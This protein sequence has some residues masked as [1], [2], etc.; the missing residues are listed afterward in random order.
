MEALEDRTEILCSLW[1]CHIDINLLG[2]E[3]SPK[4]TLLTVRK[5]DARKWQAWTRPVD[6]QQ[7]RFV[8]SLRKHAV[9]GQ[10]QTRVGR[11][12]AVSGKVLKLRRL[13]RHMIDDQVS[14][15]FNRRAEG[16]K[17]VPTS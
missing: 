16:S 12:F 13:D 10:E 7:L 5:G 8:R 3:R 2:S 17:I 6:P 14:D 4:Q 11:T 15:Q 1:V 9:K